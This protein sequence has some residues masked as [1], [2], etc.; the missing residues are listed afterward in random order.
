MTSLTQENTQMSVVRIFQRMQKTSLI[1]SLGDGS[2]CPL[3]RNF[4]LDFGGNRILKEI[5]CLYRRVK[6]LLEYQ[7]N[8][9][10]RRVKPECYALRFPQ[11]D[12]I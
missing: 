6:E 3:V 8:Y 4:F 2:T 12:D 9:H 7:L 5:V 10:F 11:L 1:D